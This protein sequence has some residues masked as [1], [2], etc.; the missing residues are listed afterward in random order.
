M[1]FAPRPFIRR[2]SSAATPWTWSILLPDAILCRQLLDLEV[3]GHVHRQ[4]LLGVVLV[5]PPKLY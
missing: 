1:S 5:G 2:Q 4:R 3:H